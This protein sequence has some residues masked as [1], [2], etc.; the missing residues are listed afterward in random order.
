MGS[1]YMNELLQDIDRTQLPGNEIRHLL[2]LCST[3]IVCW[4]IVS[5]SQ[6]LIVIVHFSLS[7]CILIYLFSLLIIAMVGGEFT[8]FTTYEPYAFGRSYFVPDGWITVDIPNEACSV[9][10]SDSAKDSTS[11]SSVTSVHTVGKDVVSQEVI[12]SCETSI[13]NCESTEAICISTTSNN[14]VLLR[15]FNLTNIEYADDGVIDN[16]SICY[17]DSIY[18]TTNVQTEY[19]DVKGDVT[20][21]VDDVHSVISMRTSGI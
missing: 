8:G 3:Y 13:E 2:V 14:C 21:R 1:S 20:T 6:L 9:T 10:D 7:L 17:T 11:G 18:N 16:T 19:S 15:Q 12:Q 4:E 5:S